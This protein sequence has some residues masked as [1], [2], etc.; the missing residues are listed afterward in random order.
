MDEV[1]VSRWLVLGDL[2]DQRLELD[3]PVSS[4]G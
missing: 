3:Q 4:L 1:Q 2:L